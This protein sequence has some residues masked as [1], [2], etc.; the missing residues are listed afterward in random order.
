MV[1]KTCKEC[2]IEQSLDNYHKAGKSGYQPK[3]KPCRNSTRDRSSERISARVRKYNVSIE[4]LNNKL[5][6]GCEVC[7]SYD[8]LVV[9]HDNKC[10][11]MGRSR[12][13][14][15]CGDCV[16]GILCNDC[17]LAIGYM[18]DDMDRMIKAV[19]YLRRAKG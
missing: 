13:S 12:N 17:N 2:G 16:R 1:L 9:D 10:C 6:K 8:R 15:S 19:E 18:K 7:G 14:K 11:P 5:A 4:W 3:C